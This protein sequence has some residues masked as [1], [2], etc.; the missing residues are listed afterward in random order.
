[1]GSWK[2]TLCAGVAVVAAVLIPTAY[3]S[4]EGGSVT[5]TPS[6]PTPGAEVTLKVGG[7]GGRTATATSDAFVTDARLVTTGGGT[8]AGDTRVRT[9]IGP[10]IYDVKITCVDSEVRG[11]ITVVASTRTRP[12]ESTTPTWPASPDSPDS[13]PSPIAPVHAGGGGTA[14]LAPV[15]PLAS[16]DEARVGEGGGPG[17]AQTVIGLV[18]AGVAATV[19]VFRGLRRRRATD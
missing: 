16:A 8:L 18:L 17:T 2:V 14:P 11:R 10:G 3:A 7:C 12:G 5:M 15:A 9:S 1:M 19:V 4:D 6:A 13:P